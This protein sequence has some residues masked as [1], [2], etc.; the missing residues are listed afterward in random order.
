MPGGK[1]FPRLFQRGP[2]FCF[3]IKVTMA[4]VEGRAAPVV[5]GLYSC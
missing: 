3:C 5:R 2:G 1:R 4:A